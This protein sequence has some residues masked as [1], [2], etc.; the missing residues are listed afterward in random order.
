V[1]IKTDGI[2]VEI[3]NMPAT[4]FMEGLVEMD[5]F[6]RIKIDHQTQRTNIAGIWA[7]GDCTD[8]LYHQNNIA[9]GDAVKALEDIYLGLARK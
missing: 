6:K 1:E 4:S 2:F 3:G 8:T 5:E 9:A 7:A